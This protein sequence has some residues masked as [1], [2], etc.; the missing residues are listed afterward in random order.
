M[1]LGAMM[2]AWCSLLAWLRGEAKFSA[3][4]VVL[5]QGGTQLP[6]PVNHIFSMVF[7]EMV[8]AG[9][10]A[11]D[12][13]TRAGRLKRFAPA[14]GALVEAVAYVCLA[15]QLF[16]FLCFQ[17]HNWKMTLGALL[18][19]WLPVATML[20]VLPNTKLGGERNEE[21]GEEE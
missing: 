20:P 11:R 7:S 8:R 19:L 15:I 13:H 9:K 3:L 14:V 17:S 2:T 10:A 16:F 5:L 6:K 18:F 12:E 4:L 1:L 21:D